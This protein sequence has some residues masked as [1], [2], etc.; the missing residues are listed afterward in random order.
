MNDIIKNDP[1][2]REQRAEDD[3]L[4]HMGDW[5]WVKETQGWDSGDRKKGDTW[6]WLGCVMQVGSNFVELHSPHGERGYKTQRVHLD[7]MDDVLRF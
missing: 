7:N 1:V 4:P 5:Y 2:S 3:L 6:E